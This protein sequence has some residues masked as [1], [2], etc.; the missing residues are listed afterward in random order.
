MRST[1]LKSLL[2][3]AALA[4]CAA[5]SELSAQGYPSRSITVVVPFP[6]GG[7]SDVVARIV[8]DHMSNTLGHQLV[9][10]N[11]GGAGGTRADED[12]LLA[13]GRERRLIVESRAV[14][15]PFEAAAVHVD[16]PQVELAPARIGIVRR[17]D[18]ALPAR[19]K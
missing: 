17:E 10:E 18:Y 13:V 7:P 2:C 1:T 14:G 16:R 9:I 15:Q 3:V 8:T 19:K 5:P 6:A 11:F 4:L 12:Q